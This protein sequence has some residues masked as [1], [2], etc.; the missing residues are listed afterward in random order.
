VAVLYGA[1]LVQRVKWPG[2][3]EPTP[4]PRV[5]LVDDD[6]GIRALF[7]RVLE[8]A[9]YDAVSAPDGAAG[10][11]RLQSDPRIQL[12]ILD[13]MMPGMDGWR[14]RSLQRQDPRIASIPT[15]IMTGAPLP[16]VVDAELAASGYIFK[17]VTPHDFLDIVTQHCRPGVADDSRSGSVSY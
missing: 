9:G 5:L 7:T 3:R 10:F 15:V 2:I 11:A 6:S 12:L 8:L 17:P 1:C 13:L 14:F 16:A 4:S